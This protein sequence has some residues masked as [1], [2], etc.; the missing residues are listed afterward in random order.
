EADAD[1]LRV[2]LDELA[3]RILQTAA[4]GDGS[5]QRGVEVGELLAANG[6]GRIDA[7]SGLVDDHVRQIH[8]RALDRWQRRGCR[9]GSGGGGGGGCAAAPG[10][11]GGGGGAVGA[12]AGCGTAGTDDVAYRTEGVSSAISGVA[13]AGVS[14]AGATAGGGKGGAGGGAGGRGLPS[15]A[16]R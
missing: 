8:R 7:R 16:I 6:T 2:D 13:S 1:V 11:G 3:E 5:A 10:G 14:V 4:D 12:G 9:L 15:V